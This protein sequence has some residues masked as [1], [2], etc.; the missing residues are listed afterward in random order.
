MP[1]FAPV[2]SPLAIG[3]G[4]SVLESAGRPVGDSDEVDGTVVEL[5]GI[6]LKEVCSESSA[7]ELPVVGVG[8]GNVD[9]FV[10]SA[11]VDEVTSVVEVA[12]TVVVVIIVVSGS[13]VVVGVDIDVG[14][15]VG[16]GVDVDEGEL[17]GACSLSVHL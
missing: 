2:L 4:V 5:V 16:V 8:S 14:V 11:L 6:L 10:V 7:D 13:F 15:G 17:V 3:F 9:D 12:G 1:A